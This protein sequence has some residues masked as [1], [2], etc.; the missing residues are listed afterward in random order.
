MDGL[1]QKCKG[2]IFIL[3]LTISTLSYAVDTI[4]LGDAEQFFSQPEV[5]GDQIGH[6]CAESIKKEYIKSK[7]SSLIKSSLAMLAGGAAIAGGIA[8]SSAT[9]NPAFATAGWVIGAPLLGIGGLRSL[10]VG[11]KWMNKENSHDFRKARF[12]E[13]F[14][15]SSPEITLTQQKYYTLNREKQDYKP[16]IRVTDG[17]KENWWH[18]NDY[19]AYL[20]KQ[21]KL[22][23]RSYSVLKKLK[24]G[25]K[26]ANEDISYTR[27]L[28]ENLSRLSYGRMKKVLDNLST[29]TFSQKVKEGLRG[30]IESTKHFFGQ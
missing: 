30:G 14:M 13:G 6:A 11:N 27:G 8:C 21:L 1:M 24:W 19:D 16:I 28:C 2:F 18:E 4:E 5:V 3:F 12:I 29:R 7:R 22:S 15:T 20:Q 26:L 10:Y 25:Q 23:P 17:K 9:L